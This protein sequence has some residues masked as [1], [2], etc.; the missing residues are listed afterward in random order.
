MFSC[1]K[2]TSNSL[3]NTLD[4]L[5]LAC[6]AAPLRQTKGRVPLL[7]CT[8]GTTTTRT[9]T[10]RVWLETLQQHTRYLHCRFTHTRVHNA[11]QWH[12]N[13]TR[14]TCTNVVRLR[15]MQ[16]WSS[17]CEYWY[18]IFHRCWILTVARPYAEPAQ[19][20]GP[21]IITCHFRIQRGTYQDVVSDIMCSLGR[22]RIYLCA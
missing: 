5:L 4:G 1:L 22:K 9:S 6:G 2:T 11:A 7:L 16:S 18:K 21:T 12:N 15:T 8:K 20:C 14:S 3:I 10:Q 19:Y 13:E 17:V